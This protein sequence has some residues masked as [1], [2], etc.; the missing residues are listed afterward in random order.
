MIIK[1]RAIM[2]FKNL[3]IVTLA[4]LLQLITLS[5]Y[6]QICNGF[7]ELC[8]KR[9][10]E[11]VYVEAHNASSRQDQSGKLA[12]RPELTSLEKLVLKGATKASKA[13]STLSNP[14]GDQHLTVQQQLQAGVRSFEFHVHFDYPHPTTF[15]TVL[16]NGI[17]SQLTNKL[18]TTLANAQ[19]DHAADFQ[20]LTN[21]QTAVNNL[22]N[23]LNNTNQKIQKLEKWFN[24]LPKFSF[25]GDSKTVRGIDYAA[26]DAALK[27]EKTGIQ[28]SIA[29]ATGILN[30][31]TT[32]WKNLTENSP[33]ILK[34]KAELAIAQQAL[35]AFELVAP[36]SQAGKELFA[37]HGLVKGDLYSAIPQDASQIYDSMIEG[38][39]SG[40]KSFINLPT[41][42][43]G[44]MAINNPKDTFKNLFTSIVGPLLKDA[45]SLITSSY[46]QTTKET[47][48]GILPYTPCL[49]DFARK[50]L[51]KLLADIKQWLDTHPTDVI[52]LRVND[53]AKS[54]N[55]MAPL[56]TQSGILHYAYLQDQTKLWPTLG[57]LIK[58]NKRLIIFKSDPI[59]GMMNSRSFFFPVSSKF[60]YSIATDIT[61]ESSTS[62]DNIVSPSNTASITKLST[63]PQNKLFDFTHNITIGIA[64]SP[65]AATQVNAK[66]VL[67]P[68]LVKLA[69]AL[70][71]VPN[72]ITLDFVNLPNAEVFDAV[73]MFNGVG[74][75][76]GKPAW[77][78]KALATQPAKT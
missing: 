37:C 59:A 16:L 25:K 64:G 63:D 72:F 35:Q 26:R 41:I 7:K 1:E 61:K 28:G 14:A 48:S 66:N 76:A 19:K 67:L 39:S 24:N 73:N 21:A 3:G 60:G 78:P 49:T 10:N 57:E 36:L 77:T 29:V 53:F 50:P 33:E 2:V 71:H 18:N 32:V 22:Q 4:I 55:A 65:E 51:A 9:Y 75:Y 27:T 45:Q 40:F 23:D 43:I 54:N 20:K 12:D 5:A 11:V 8:N 58:T 56:F 47:D 44:G 13:L 52:T 15:Y 30:A 42:V 31:A 70:N 68:R 62:I 6:A 74:H 69:N 34:Q 38:S 46:G 17:V